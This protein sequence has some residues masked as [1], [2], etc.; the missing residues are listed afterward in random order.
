MKLPP[1]NPQIDQDD[2]FPWGALIG[3]VFGFIF[4]VMFVTSACGK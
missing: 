3:F 4:G 1:R 2:P